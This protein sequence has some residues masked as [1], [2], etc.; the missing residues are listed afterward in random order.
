MVP[1]ISIHKITPGFCPVS[2]GYDDFCRIMTIT[3][4]F[5]I[6][7]NFSHKFKG[8]FKIMD[9]RKITYGSSKDKNTR[10]DLPGLCF[11]P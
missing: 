3:G 5:S 2:G 4:I 7:Y 9:E 10:K 8:S 1:I 6:I 11:F